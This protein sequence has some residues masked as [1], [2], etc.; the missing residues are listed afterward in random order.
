MKIER[1]NDMQIRCTLTKEDLD[2]REIRLGE[3]AYGS[4]KAKELFRDMMERAADEV[5]FEADDT[6]LMIEAVPLSMDSIVLIIS[7]VDSPEELDTRFS[8]FTENPDDEAA[9]AV[10]ER[11]VSDEE[12]DLFAMINQIRSR[13]D[14]VPKQPEKT[15]APRIR[16]FRF[17]ELDTAIS[18]AHSLRSFYFGPSTL[19]R[20][21]RKG[22]YYLAMGQG[23]MSEDDFNRVSHM[24]SAFLTAEK[25]TPGGAAFLKEHMKVVL[26][27]DAIERLAAI[28]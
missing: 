12:E 11:P 19:Y 23:N 25:Y 15:A 3:L 8:S 13:R 16:L 17:A 7:K 1:I 5:G 4:D 21:G 26:D 27:G 22:I 18:L 28:K 14:T 9:D 2:E 24:A 6:P 10:P 20:D